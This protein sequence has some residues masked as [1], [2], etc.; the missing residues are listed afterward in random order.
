MGR[1]IGEGRARVP[2]LL[3]KKGAKT[4]GPDIVLDVETMWVIER[5]AVHPFG[6][7]EAIVVV[8]ILLAREEVLQ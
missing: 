4:K 2:C 6:Y 1:E 3:D 5:R 7:V 8:D